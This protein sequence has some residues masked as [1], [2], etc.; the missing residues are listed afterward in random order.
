[1]LAKKIIKILENIRNW[2]WQFTNKL[3]ELIQFPNN[4]KIPKDQNV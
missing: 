4:I 3:Q 2:E 1:M